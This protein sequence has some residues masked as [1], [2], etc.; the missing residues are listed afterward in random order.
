M[1]GN[2]WFM[3]KENLER[4][5]KTWQE[6]V[7]CNI[8]NEFVDS[9]CSRWS[10][11]LWLCLCLCIRLSFS[12][13]EPFQGNC[14]F[15]MQEVVYPDT[16]CVWLCFCTYI[17]LCPCLLRKDLKGNCKFLM[18]EVVHPAMHTLEGSIGFLYWLKTAKVVGR[19]CF[20]KSQ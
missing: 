10:N 3:C 18:Q 7:N 1:T 19:N 13:L 11:S 20:V 8:W 12:N 16:S 6:N 2:G 15:L 17:Y 5:N 9:Q 14:K 4:E